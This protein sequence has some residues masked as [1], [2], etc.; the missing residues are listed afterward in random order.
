MSSTV[1]L[2]RTCKFP[3]HTENTIFF[4]LAAE[5]KRMEKGEQESLDET[6]G[7][8]LLSPP[9]NNSGQ[10]GLVLHFICGTLDKTQPSKAPCANR[11]SPHSTNGIATCVGTAGLR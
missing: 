7:L 8:C 1:I 10:K 3:F 6:V 5:L 2:G 4:E 11:Q 9:P